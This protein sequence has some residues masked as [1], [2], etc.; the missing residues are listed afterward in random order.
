MSNILAE[1]L[2]GADFFCQYEC[3]RT[4]P[5][6]LNRV[7][8]H[9]NFNVPVWSLSCSPHPAE[10]CDREHHTHTNPFHLR[11]SE[12][13][14]GAIPG[15]SGKRWV[16]IT[17]NKTTSHAVQQQCQL[18][19]IR[20]MHVEMHIFACTLWPCLS[21]KATPKTYNLRNY[22]PSN[23]N[24]NLQHYVAVYVITNNIM[25]VHRLKIKWWCLQV[26][27]FSLLSHCLNK[28]HAK[29]TQKKPKRK[30]IYMYTTL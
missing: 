19:L 20:H 7:T 18:G 29:E 23:E 22:H 26:D 1:N 3:R 2:A 13:T 5:C 30:K 6:L 27:D 9:H 14:Q 21:K 17:R 28:W 24:W 11:T 4:F 15:W 12:P 8:F 25:G 10:A 16:K